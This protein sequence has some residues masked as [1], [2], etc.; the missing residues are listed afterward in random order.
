MGR[1]ETVCVDLSCSD[2]VSRRPRTT[3]NG[4]S[5]RAFVGQNAPSGPQTQGSGPA[6]AVF[7]YRKLRQ[8]E[9]PALAD[10][11]PPTHRAPSSPV[12]LP[13]DAT[14]AGIVTTGFGGFGGFGGFESEAFP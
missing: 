7:D 14:P 3:T 8:Q 13:A 2:G 9:M 6:L 12:A 10:R 1:C 11:Q 4:T 5:C